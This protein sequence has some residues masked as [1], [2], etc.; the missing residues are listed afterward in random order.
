MGQALSAWPANYR[1]RKEKGCS[2]NLRLDRPHG[3]GARARRR[4]WPA[5]Q[6]TWAGEPGGRTLLPLGRRRRPVLPFGREGQWPGER[7]QPHPHPGA[8]SSGWVPKGR[9]ACSSGG[10]CRA[11]RESLRTNPARPS[12]A[13]HAPPTSLFPAR[14]QSNPPLKGLTLCRVTFRSSANLLPLEAFQGQG[15]P[16]FF[17]FSF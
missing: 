9:T 2:D 5:R 10:M 17:R 11:R 6:V 1:M 15:K 3:G 13:S 16:K 8:S 4:R 12:R 7:A 14:D